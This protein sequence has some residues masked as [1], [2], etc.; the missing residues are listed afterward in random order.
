MTS[1]QNIREVLERELRG[2]VDTQVLDVEEIVNPKVISRGACYESP[3]LHSLN[4]AIIPSQETTTIAGLET[5]FRGIHKDLGN[6]GLDFRYS[7]F[8][9]FE[10]ATKGGHPMHNFLSGFYVGCMKLEQVIG[11]YDRVIVEKHSIS[12]R[13]GEED[14]AQRLNCDENRSRE[15]VEESKGILKSERG[16]TVRDLPHLERFVFIT[17]Y[18]NPAH[19]GEE[20][21]GV[22][23]DRDWF[24][25]TI[26]NSCCESPH[27]R[28]M[29]IASARRYLSAKGFKQFMGGCREFAKSKGLGKIFFDEHH[30]EYEFVELADNFW[31]G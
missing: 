27:A 31:R 10:C 6:F 5:W 18:I 19:F 11:D 24:Q 7:P 14:L 1:S 13:P 2:R 9:W 12:L 25:R 28:L 17:P 26:G 15:V 8:H 20:Y 4:F 3:P 21:Y 23:G 16:S 30:K 22:D 29:G